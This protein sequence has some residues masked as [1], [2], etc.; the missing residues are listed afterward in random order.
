MMTS[1]F[2]ASSGSMISSII[3]R[4]SICHILGI[5]IE[6]FMLKI[7]SSCFIITIVHIDDFAFDLF[8]CL[9]T[10]LL[11]KLVVMMVVMM[12]YIFIY[13]YYYLVLY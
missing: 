9:L 6:G 13:Y 1:I 2:L 11:V 8:C 12:I 10:I 7:G 5:G 3:S 4:S